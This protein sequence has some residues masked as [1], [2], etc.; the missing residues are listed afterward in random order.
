VAA[1]NLS[2][3]SHLLLFDIEA[4][5]EPAPFRSSNT[6]LS[7]RFSIWAGSRPASGPVAGGSYTRLAISAALPSRRPAASRQAVILLT[8][9]SRPI[10]RAPKPS[11]ASSRALSNMPSG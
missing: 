10:D 5:C 6:A 1:L 3:S 9:S 8:P 2:P 4:R 7:S 11:A